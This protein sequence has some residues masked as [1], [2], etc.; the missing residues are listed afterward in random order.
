MNPD[1][2]EPEPLV[3]TIVVCPDGS[4]YKNIRLEC[5]GWIHGIGIEHIRFVSMWAA[6]S[7]A[8]FHANGSPAILRILGDPFSTLGEYRIPPRQ[9]IPVPHHHDDIQDFMQFF[10]TWPMG[11][12]MRERQ[13][14]ERMAWY[15]A[16]KKK[17]RLR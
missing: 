13:R 6:A 1:I 15:E 2:E 5:R 12:Q 17:G 14:A 3:C 9:E 4:R 16:E 11:F 10:S 8:Q 7:F